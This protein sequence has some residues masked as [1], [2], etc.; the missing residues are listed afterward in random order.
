MEGGE[1]AMAPYYGAM[2]R[3]DHIETQTCFP[4]GGRCQLFI[5]QHA[6]RQ[7]HTEAAEMFINP[8]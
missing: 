5:G 6:F 3:D 1:A 4:P 2:P 7:R 8:P